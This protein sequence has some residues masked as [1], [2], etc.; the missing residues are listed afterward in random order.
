M[1]FLSR[2]TRWM[3]F[4][5]ITRR[6]QREV[7]SRRTAYLTRWWPSIQLNHFYCFKEARRSG[8]REPPSRWRFATRKSNFP[9]RRPSY[10]NGVT[11]TSW[12]TSS[13]IK[14]SVMSRCSRHPTRKTPSRSCESTSARR[15]PTVFHRS[16]TRSAHRSWRWTESV[17]RW[18]RH[19]V[20]ARKASLIRRTSGT[21]CQ[22]RPT[23]S[24]S[25]F[26]TSWQ[27]K[28]T[29]KTARAFA[30]ITRRLEGNSTLARFPSPFDPTFF[31]SSRRASSESYQWHTVRP[32]AHTRRSRARGSTSLASTWELTVWEGKS[33][34][35]SCGMATRSNRWHKTQISIR[36]TS[37]VG[38]S[39]KWSEFSPEITL[40]SNV[41]TTRS[42]ASS[43]RSAESRRMKSCA[44][45]RWCTI[46]SRSS[47]YRVTRKPTSRICWRRWELRI[48]GKT[49][50][51]N[52]SD[53]S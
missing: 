24:C 26:I 41:R 51:R 47:W 29:S 17:S 34:S 22:T 3:S 50:K 6:S 13:G 45:Q 9:S 2:M 7:K 36:I 32:T 40:P 5:C 16:K 37:R 28:S 33:K 21:Q 39:R 23:T 49:S 38:F 46:R 1:P 25:R 10:L 35:E 11:R 19:G 44:W 48:W 20:E 8:P 52:V 12:K 18:W 43:S 15:P 4:S 30:F 14:S 31:I 27:R 42:S 53:G